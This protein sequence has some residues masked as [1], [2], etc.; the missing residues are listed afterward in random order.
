MG[1]EL[2]TLKTTVPACLSKRLCLFL[3]SFLGHAIDAKLNPSFFWQKNMIFFAGDQT[4]KYSSSD[5]R[6]LKHNL[7]G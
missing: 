3:L 2:T 5:N 7:D 6:L 4:F 1:F